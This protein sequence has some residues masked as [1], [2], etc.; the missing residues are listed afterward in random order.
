VPDDLRRAIKIVGK[1]ITDGTLREVQQSPSP[2]CS[3]PFQDLAN[4]GA[5]DD[6]LS[7]DFQCLHCGQGFH[8]GA[9]TYHGS[10]GSWHPVGS[11]A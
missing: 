9:E 1:S 2:H 7:Y 3:V 10:G 4:G 6:I 8:L 5:W 11:N